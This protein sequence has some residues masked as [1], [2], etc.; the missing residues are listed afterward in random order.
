[1]QGLT[2]IYHNNYYM[3]YNTYI[4]QEGAVYRLRAQ[5][6]TVYSLP[7]HLYHEEMR[8]H[9]YSPPLL[10]AGDPVHLLPWWFSFPDSLQSTTHIHMR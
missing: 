10:G 3:Q 4:K 6:A 5:S 7:K 9:Q 1:M 2:I 8:T